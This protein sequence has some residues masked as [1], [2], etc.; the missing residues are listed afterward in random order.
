V[1]FAQAK[2]RTKSRHSPICHPPSLPLQCQAA[3]AR[4][5]WYDRKV[6]ALP[7]EVADRLG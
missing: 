5:P 6:A 4:L 7:G 1:G 3:T 2:Y